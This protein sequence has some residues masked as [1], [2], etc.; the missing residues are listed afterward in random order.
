MS[1]LNAVLRFFRREDHPPTKAE[2]AEA[3]KAH[4]RVWDGRTNDMVDGKGL[5]PTGAV[6]D[7][8]GDSKP[9]S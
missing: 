2:E 9:S 8:E 4:D 1:K 3:E 5:S 7:F 6:M